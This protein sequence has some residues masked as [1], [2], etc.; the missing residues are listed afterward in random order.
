MVGSGQSSS[1]STSGIVRRSYEVI[2]RKRLPKTFR[3]IAIPKK[4]ERKADSPICWKRCWLRGEEGAVRVGFGAPK[5]GAL[6][7]ASTYSVTDLY[8]NASAAVRDR[9]GRMPLQSI[10]GH[11]FNVSAWTAS[12]YRRKSM[13]PVFVAGAMRVFAPGCMR[14]VKVR[15]DGS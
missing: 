12:G 5:A 2:R 3:I 13:A 15:T 8:R 11:W 4:S 14:L 6:P 1:S 7:K 10:S 9:R